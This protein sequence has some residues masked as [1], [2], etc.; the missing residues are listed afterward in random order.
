MT[1][2]PHLVRREIAVGAL[3]IAGVL[4]WSMVRPAPLGSIAN[5]QHSPNPAKAAW[6]LG[7]IQELLLHMETLAAILLVALLLVGMALLPYVDR[8]TADI[9]IYFRSRVGRRAALV[10]AILSLDLVPLLVVL[11]ENWSG[12]S[13]LLPNLD[14]FVANGLLPGAEID[15]AQASATKARPPI[16]VQSKVIRP[17][18]ADSAQHPA[19]YCSA[20]RWSLNK[21]QHSGYATH[22]SV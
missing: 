18:M 16:A 11:D 15:D 17:P 6:F 5:P 10:G 21:V 19:Q 4:V 1:T 2:L 8:E 13:S 22:S 12:F 14:P 7:G 20:E 9:G 3:V